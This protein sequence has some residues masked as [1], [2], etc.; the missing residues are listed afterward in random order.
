MTQ[1]WTRPDNRMSTVL[2]KLYSTRQFEFKEDLQSTVQSYLWFWYRLQTK[3][4]WIQMLQ[5]WVKSLDVSRVIWCLLC[6]VKVLIKWTLVVCSRLKILQLPQA[7]ECIHSTA[8]GHGMYTFYTL[9]YR[10]YTFYI[11]I[12]GMCTFYDIFNNYTQFFCTKHC[13][14]WTEM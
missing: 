5:I 2:L 4:H 7:I 10:M 9:F 3:L 13:N 1:T 12:C 8:C 11:S 6:D 14:K